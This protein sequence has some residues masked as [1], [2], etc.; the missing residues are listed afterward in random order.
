MRLM[1]AGGAIFYNLEANENYFFVIRHR[2]H[3][4]IMT[5]TA[6]TL[7]NATPYDLTVSN[8]IMGGDS[9]VTLL[10]NNDYAMRAGDFNANGIGSVADFNQ[11]ALVVGQVNSYFQEDCNLD[12]NITV[13]DYNLYHLNTSMIGIA[14]TR[15]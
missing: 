13:A 12:G 2:N 8:S 7:N 11:Y 9:Q 10:A 4:A 5:S 6:L 1:V 14:Q 15:Y 3:L